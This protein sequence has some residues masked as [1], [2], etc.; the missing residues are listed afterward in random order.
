MS[1]EYV[2]SESDE[3]R[4]I[5]RRRFSIPLPWVA[6]YFCFLHV[7]PMCRVISSWFVLLVR[8]E[9]H[10]NNQFYCII[11]QQPNLIIII[12]IQKDYNC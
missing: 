11:K 6:T 4:G 9:S 1:S 8:I 2:R 5:V 3:V 7:P 10:P 12:I